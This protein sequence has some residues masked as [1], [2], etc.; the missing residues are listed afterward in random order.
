MKIPNLKKI[1]QPNWAH[2]PGYGMNKE[3]LKK[4]KVVEQATTPEDS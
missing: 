2:K 4:Q 1:I 3:G